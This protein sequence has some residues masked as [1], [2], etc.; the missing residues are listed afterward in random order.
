MMATAL[1]AALDA[2][3][4]KSRSITRPYTPWEV[5]EIRASPMS[6]QTLNNIITTENNEIESIDRAVA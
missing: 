3:L 5:T 1:D 4:D 6:R 2:A